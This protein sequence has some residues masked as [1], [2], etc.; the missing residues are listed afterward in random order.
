M[1]GAGEW[2]T[3]PRLRTYFAM[4]R[5]NSSSLAGHQPNAVTASFNTDCAIVA[6]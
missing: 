1:R 6:G 5:I 4:K 3:T 2:L